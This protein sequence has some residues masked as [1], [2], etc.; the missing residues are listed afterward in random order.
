MLT[1]V[2]DACVLYPAPLRDRLMHLALTDLFR[3]KWSATIHDEWIRNVLANRPDL[4]RE[5]LERT[6]RLMD[7]HVRDALI[8]GYEALIDT[9]A[10]PDPD[11]RHVLAAA[12]VSHADLIITFNHRDFPPA[13][14]QPYGILIQ[15]PDRFI[16]H[17]MTMEVDDV[18]AA[19]RRHRQSLKNPPKS[20]DEYLT[21]L[22]RQR[23]PETVER[24]RQFRHLL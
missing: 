11:D 9:L 15:H 19:L 16:V 1:V 23:L 14:L 7:T 13:T 21:I 3:A 20:V 22:D 12:I 5:Q 18:C 10:L 17:L 24:L 8:E 6:R 4:S 2:Y